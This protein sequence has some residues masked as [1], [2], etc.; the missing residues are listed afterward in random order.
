M[1]N[2]LKKETKELK[3]CNRNRAKDT[4][5]LIIDKEVQTNG[6]RKYEISTSHI[7]GTSSKIS[8]SRKF[9]TPSE[10]MTLPDSWVVSVLGHPAVQLLSV[11]P[12]AGFH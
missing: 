2:T 7:D 11:R 1:K 4:N 5:P 12:T 9:P 10:N 6:Q 8:Q 3:Q